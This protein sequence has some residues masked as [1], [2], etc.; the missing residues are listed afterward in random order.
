MQ[1]DTLS[2]VHV[3]FSHALFLAWYLLYSLFIVLCYGSCLGVVARPSTQSMKASGNVA[4]TA[5]EVPISLT[6]SPG[7]RLKMTATQAALM[8]MH[9]RSTQ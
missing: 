3:Q 8:S 4:S 5:Q 7:K 1:P 9:Q 2:F 6:Q